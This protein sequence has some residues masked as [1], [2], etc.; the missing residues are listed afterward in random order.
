MALVLRTL[1][2]SELLSIRHGVARPAPEDTKELECE[3]ADLILL[4]I[5]GVLAKHDGP[6]QHVI[7]NANHAI[8]LGTGQPYRITFPGDIGD[9]ALVL[10][11]SKE[12]LIQ[13]L[14]EVAGVEQLYV[15][16]LRPH[17][18]LPPASVLNRELLWRHLQAPVVDKLAVQEISVSMLTASVQAACVDIRQQERARQ[19]LTQVRRRQQVESV[20]ELLSLYP[21]QEWALDELARHVHTTPF[22]LSRVFRE[23]VGLPVHRYLIRTRLAQALR[24]MQVA[25]TDLTQIA[26]A[27]GFANHSHFTSSFRSVFGM[28]PTQSRQRSS[29]L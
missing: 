28:T 20:K 17:C 21:H 26:H 27:S 10:D 22:H 12:A 5:A 24:A 8:F 7:A 1:F 19:R 29:M 2:Q 15:P 16:A 25:C 3:T 23:E 4:P 18:L 13:I 14:S 6:K 9:E 11:F